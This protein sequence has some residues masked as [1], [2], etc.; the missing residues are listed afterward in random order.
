MNHKKNKL[1][2]ETDEK[3]HRA[4]LG[5]LKEQ[6]NPTIAEICRRCAINRTTFYLHYA[7]I[8]ELLEAQQKHM[9][10]KVMQEFEESDLQVSLMSYN[11]YVLFAKHVK[12]NK[13]FYR[14]FF[15]VN[16]NFPLEVEYENLWEQIVVPYYHE[17]GLFDET[18]MRL[19][20]VCF[21]AGFTICLGKWVE[22]DCDLSC[23]EVAKIL[24]E[25]ITL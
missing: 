14:F 17:Q 25:C 16:K 4:L 3:I 21:Q 6:K 11:S 7:D 20:F 12:A 1:Y 15:R 5:I 8:E 22:N 18:I 23:E 2:H 13:D 19:R 9:N 10:K 24:S